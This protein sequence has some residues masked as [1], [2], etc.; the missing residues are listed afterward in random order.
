MINIRPISDLRNKFTEIEELV[1]E[2]ELVYLT[3]NGYGTMVVMSIE[4]YASLT[5]RID[6]KLAETE[7]IAEATPIDGLPR[8]KAKDSPFIN[9]RKI[10]DYH[11]MILIPH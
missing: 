7:R 4:E 2:G 5:E 11:P 3:K 10:K 9:F 1:K 6:A 8:H